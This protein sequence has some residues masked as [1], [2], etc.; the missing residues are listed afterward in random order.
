MGAK[1]STAWGRGPSW[2]S[3]RAIPGPPLVPSP[4]CSSSH[5]LVLADSSGQQVWVRLQGSS[6]WQQAKVNALPLP[7]NLLGQAGSGP[8]VEAIAGACVGTIVALVAVALG[9]SNGFRHCKE[10]MQ[11]AILTEEQRSYGA[12]ETTAEPSAV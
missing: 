7:A 4:P 9:V 10:K 1:S 5:G 11:G 6:R 12:I 8:R 2:T 3:S